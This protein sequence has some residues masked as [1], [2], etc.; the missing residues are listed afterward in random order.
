MC[1][2]G[3]CVIYV[4]VY[5]HLCVCPAWHQPR[6][7]AKLPISEAQSIKTPLTTPL[8]K[9]TKHARSQKHSDTQYTHTYCT[10]A[11]VRLPFCYRGTLTTLGPIHFSDQGHERELHQSA[12]IWTDRPPPSLTSVLLVS[13][14][15]SQHCLSH[16]HTSNKFM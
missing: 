14:L 13:K 2:S 3:L 8:S 15:H 9:K 10:Y 4:C 16:F 6:S 5:M 7:Y 11:P 12:Y 1:L